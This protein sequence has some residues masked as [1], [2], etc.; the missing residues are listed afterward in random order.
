MGVS[1]GTAYLGILVAQEP[2]EILD[3]KVADANS[4]HLAGLNKL[5]H[6]SPGLNV[7]PVLVDGLFLGWVDRSGPVHQVEV[8]VVRLQLLEGFG[9]GLGDALVVRVAVKSVLLA[10]LYCY[11]F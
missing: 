1:T 11:Q 2:F 9:E 8:Q 6:L 10:T 4:L 5:L 3:G 7:I